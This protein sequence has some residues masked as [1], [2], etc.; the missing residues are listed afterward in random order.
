V[1]ERAAAREAAQIVGSLG[2]SP[3]SRRTTRTQAAAKDAGAGRVAH[4]VLRWAK[5]NG[6]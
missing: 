6:W 1:A 2:V 3:A 5:S 4:R